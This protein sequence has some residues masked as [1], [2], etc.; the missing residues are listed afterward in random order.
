LLL[1]FALILI[2]KKYCIKIFILMIAFFLYPLKFFAQGKYAYLTLLPA[3]CSISEDQ[4]WG[5]GYSF[6]Y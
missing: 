1:F 2:F 5:N 6:Y 4:E 3:L